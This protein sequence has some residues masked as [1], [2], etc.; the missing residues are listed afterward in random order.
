M[1]TIEIHGKKYVTVNER[2]KHLR[3]NYP[4]WVIKTKFLVVN[5]N[6]ALCKATI[7]DEKGLTVATGHAYEQK[8]NTGINKSSHVENC[9]TSAVGRA[10]AY[11][12]IGIDAGIASLDEIINAS[13]VQ[14][15]EKLMLSSS[16]NDKDRE[17]IEENLLTMT[18]QDAEQVVR[19]LQ[20][21]QLDPITQGMGYNQRDIQ[22]KLDKIDK[23][24][25]K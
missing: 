8:S 22:N 5:E 23:D 2:V 18:A 15:I 6:E 21:H 14:Y 9:E 25:R 1:K 3:E 16:V 10:L 7:I 4:G 13:T 20:A 19:Y 24:P 17:K 12:G 11:V